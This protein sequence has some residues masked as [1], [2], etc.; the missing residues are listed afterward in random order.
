MRGLQF[1]IGEGKVLSRLKGDRRGRKCKCWIEERRAG[2][3]GPALNPGRQLTSTA[4]PWGGGREKRKR[5]MKRGRGKG[6]K[7]GCG[8]DK[9][10]STRPLCFSR[11]VVTPLLPREKV[12]KINWGGLKL[13][14]KDCPTDGLMRQYLLKIIKFHSYFGFP[15]NCLIPPSQK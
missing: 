1:F 3:V 9:A 8:N 2:V 15:F 4:I 13:E 5:G 11:A 10:L 7:T 6:Q 14:Q 12:N